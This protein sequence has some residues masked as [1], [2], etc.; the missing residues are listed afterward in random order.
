MKMKAVTSKFAVAAIIAITLASCAHNKVNEQKNMPVDPKPKWVDSSNYDVDDDR[1]IIIMTEVDSTGDQEEDSVAAK[2]ATKEALTKQVAELLDKNTENVAKNS[3]IAIKNPKSITPN[4]I[5]YVNKMTE[6]KIVNKLQEKGVWR[7]G[8]RTTVRY[9]VD[10]GV[11]RVEFINLVSRYR[12][13]IADDVS[14]EEVVDLVDSMIYVFK[15]LSKAPIRV[16]ANYVEPE[17]DG[18][19]DDGSEEGDEKAEEQADEQDGKSQAD[20]S[21]KNGIDESAVVSQQSSKSYNVDFT[22][23]P[24]SANKQASQTVYISNGKVQK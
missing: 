2:K 20:S 11:A 19:E 1:N 15:P 23:K 10:V 17:D 14:D 13:F 16:D 4:S 8:K 18:F 12:S 7:N 3:I 6:G 24:N 5:R 9:V 21:E 22:D